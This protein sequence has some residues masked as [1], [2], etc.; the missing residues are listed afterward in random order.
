MSAPDDHPR[1]KAWLD[2]DGDGDQLHVRVSDDGTV[3]EELDI[4]LDTLLQT[5]QYLGTFQR[6]ALS[7]LSLYERHATDEA[8]MDG[9]A[10][11]PLEV[12]D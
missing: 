6:P 12:E 3:Y 10:P 5:D 9:E 8:A 11:P 2:T 4:D 1:F 7:L